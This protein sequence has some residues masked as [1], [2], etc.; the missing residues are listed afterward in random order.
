[1]YN[2]IMKRLTIAAQIIAGI[3]VGP[4]VA[5]A[6]N[7]TVPQ[8]TGYGVV[9]VGNPNGTYTPVATSTLGIT[10][11]GGSGTISTSSPLVSGQSVYATGVNTIASVATS[12]PSIGS[13]LTYSGTLGNFINGT[14]GTFGIAN[15]A[16]TNAMLANSSLTVNGTAISLGGSG[17]ITAASST[18][19]ANNNTF[20]G[21]NAYG[22]PSSL[23][24][25]NATG[26]PNSGLLNSTISGIALGSNLNALTAT[27][28]TL[29]FSGSYNGSTAQTVGLNLANPNTWTGLQNFSNATS[30]LFSSTYAS[31]TDAYY[32][33]LHLPNLGTPAGSFLAVDGTG[34]VIATTSPS[35]GAV[36][37][38]SNSD[39][40]LTI[41]PTTGAVVASLNLAHANTWTALQSFGTAYAHI[42]NV[43]TGNSGGS[44]TFSGTGTTGSINSP[45]TA[46][47]S[48]SIGVGN[49]TGYGGLIFSSGN[50][51][52]EF[53]EGG[54]FNFNLDASALNGQ[55]RTITVPNLSG[56]LLIAS[57]TSVNGFI[58]LG[59]TT[60][61][62][63]LSLSGSSGIF[64][65][66]TATS[67]FFGGGINLVTAAGNTGCYA[68]NG[69]CLSSSSGTVT[70][71]A[72]TVPSFLSITGSPITTSGT[73]AIGYSGTA[74]PI[75][76][77]GTNATS[78]GTTNGLLA[79]NGT[80]LTN[81][82]GYTLTS[83]LFSAAN[84]TTT[85]LTSGGSNFYIDST[86]H[87][88]AKDTVHSWSGTL[89][90]TRSFSVG[91]ATTTAWLATT[92]A[93]YNLN[94]Q[95]T[96]PFSG[97]AQ[98]AVCTTDAGTLTVQFTF[99]STNVY[100]A[101]VGTTNSTTTFSGVTF[102]EGAPFALNAGNPASSPTGVNCTVYVTEN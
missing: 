5:F 66:T 58:G 89:S 32:G 18:L 57:T 19:L 33:T 60:P 31:S 76:N 47:V 3:L 6:I 65:S 38:V 56:S 43:D 2:F 93:P 53:D 75:A 44:I 34:T 92:T 74:L 36:S 64:A 52:Y 102:G 95:M 55:G 83:S 71:V 9:L 42:L 41:S 84:A 81:Y 27:N 70:S 72:A 98:Q 28:G 4:L 25:T 30:T 101:L 8:A 54:G 90:P 24:L 94:A 61:S 91:L 77:G 73:L 48:G 63:L 68:I 20:T 96:L 82:S 86:G 40:T 12:T 16:V 79:Y 85:Q 97:T 51:I 35:G 7:V 14:S 29:T 22:T 59:T 46:N 80:S 1:M 78:F 26:L 99:G 88:T 69:T 13:V 10:A 37:S 45:S 17:T 15:S 21:T 62:S 39:G 11:S 87:I 67:T 49:S 23:V 50:G 100:T